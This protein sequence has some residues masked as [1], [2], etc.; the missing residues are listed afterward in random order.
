MERGTGEIGP[1]AAPGD[2]PWWQ[3]W[4]AALLLVLLSAIPLVW[5]DIPPLTDLPGHMGRYRIQLDLAD[6]PALQRFYSFD[7][8]LIGNLGVDLLVELLAPLTGLETAVKLVVVAI[9][10]LTAAGFLWVAY[11][12][13]GKL[14]PTSLVALPLAYNFPF[15]YGFVNFALSMA[16][17]FLAFAL[18][19]RLG[20]SGRLRLRAI[21]FVPIGLV[22]WLAHVF[23]WA[24][25]GLLVFVVELVGLRAGGRGLVAAPFGAALRCLPL[26]PPVLAMLAWRSGDVGGIT[27]DWFLLRAKLGWIG[28]A[29]RDRWMIFDLLSMAVPVAL[30]VA[31]RGPTLRFHRPLAIAALALFAVYL[32]LPRILLGSAYADMRL[33]PYMIA[34]GVIAVDLRAGVAA[35]TARLFA[36][37]AVAFVAVRTGATTASMLIYDQTYRQELA[38]L[39]RLPQGARLL[40]FVGRNC[41]DTWRT[42]R[43]EHLPSIALVT[44]QAFANDQWE[45]PGAQ[46]VRVNYPAAGDFARDPSQF[47]VPQGCLGTPWTPIDQAL[48]RFP[49]RAFDHVW[50]IRPPPHAP[51]LLA[52]LRPVWRNRSS[53]LYRVE[54]SPASLDPGAGTTD[55]PH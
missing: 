27:G 9:P 45:L 36:L 14:P 49:R 21:L 5:P 33:A 25:L 53:V 43:L 4:Q 2:R 46:L 42:E 44:R 30:I 55:R 12:A 6:S 3:T 23:G 10:P 47:V 16:L 39:D 41:A 24:T 34:L 26:F 7:W 15:L 32:L 37:A 50:L 54:G 1:A 28:M 20:K 18:W 8:A 40:S 48:A 11:E 29:L 13:H 19:L 38:A 31:G 52:G 35:R 17:A 51:A 22:V